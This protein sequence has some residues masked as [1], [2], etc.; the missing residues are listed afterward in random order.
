MPLFSQRFLVLITLLGITLASVFFFFKKRELALP[1]IITPPLEEFRIGIVTDIQT[2]RKK[3]HQYGLDPTL[4]VAP[5]EKFIEHANNTFH[6]SVVVHIGDLIEGTNRRG[7]KSIEDW[8]LIDSYLARLQMPRLHVIGNHE[9][10]GLSD[11]EWKQLSGNQSTYYVYDDKNLRIL[12]LD[13]DDWGKQNDTGDEG[14]EITLPPNSPKRYTLSEEQFQWIEQTL[15]ESKGRQVAVF[16]H[17]PVDDP[18]NAPEQ[19]DRLKR[20]FSTYGVRA[21][22]AGHVETL[23]Y[24]EEGSVRYYTLPGFFRSEN[25]ST[26]HWYGT[27]YDGFLSDTFSLRMYYQKEIGGAYDS[28]LIPS[29]EYDALEK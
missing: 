20:L 2:N 3:S 15:R 6:P 14:E 8:K 13:Y 26:A 12:V 10:R 4:I 28:V 22:V 29:A 16:I 7:E 1:A 24:K 5:L 27:Y 21:V 23:S 19:R 11:T 17:V 18:V 25:K 9:R